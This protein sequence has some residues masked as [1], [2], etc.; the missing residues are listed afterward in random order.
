ME[1]CDSN[2]DDDIDDVRCPMIVATNDC[3]DRSIYNKEKKKVSLSLVPWLNIVI[4]I[5]V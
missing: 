5:H 2:V 4:S 1:T 3:Y